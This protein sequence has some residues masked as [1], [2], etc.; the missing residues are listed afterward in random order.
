MKRLTLRTNVLSKHGEARLPFSVYTVGTEEQQPMTRMKGYS[1]YQFIVTFS[2]KGRFRLLGQSKWDIVSNRQILFIPSD[3]PHEYIAEGYEPWKVGFVSFSAEANALH[4]WKLADVPTL[5][6]VQNTSRLFELIEQIWTKSGA[7]HDYWTSSELFLAFLSEITKQRYISSTDRIFYGSNAVAHAAARFLRDHV[8]RSNT[9]ITEL[10]E[11]LGYSRKQLTRLFISTY[12][13]TP[14]QYLKHQRLIGAARL[15][16]AHPER[17]ATEI[18]RQV[19]MEPVYFSRAFRIKFG[20][21]PIE[22]K[23]ISSDFDL[24]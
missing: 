19:G 21:A 9:T 16:K 8:N 24:E 13:T 6:A 22:F 20:V 10:A 4:A 5:L 7:D 11:Q 1:A 14:L 18:A 23:N 17:T 15:L 12:H 2:G 3:I